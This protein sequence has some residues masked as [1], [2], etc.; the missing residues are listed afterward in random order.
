[1]GKSKPHSD[2]VLYAVSWD[3]DGIV[4]IGF[5]D[6]LARRRKAFPAGRLILSLAFPDFD[7]GM[8]FEIAIHQ[9]AFRTWPRAFAA[10]ADAIPYLGDHGQGFMECYRTTPT[11]AFDLIASRCAVTVNRHDAT[12]HCDVTLPHD[13]TTSRSY[14][15][16]DGLTETVRDA[17]NKS[18]TLATRGR[19]TRF[20][21]F[22]CNWRLA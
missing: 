3:D 15:R 8:D 2:H 1:M 21:F 11:G 19:I 22:R 5:T 12:S 14:G 10:K 17:S 20:R 18:F 6:N 13:I 9:D 7:S 4:K 16:T